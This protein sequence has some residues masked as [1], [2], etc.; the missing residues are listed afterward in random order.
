MTRGTSLLRIYA[1]LAALVAGIWLAESVP[2]AV[3][4]GAGCCA[5]VAAGWRRRAVVS[6]IG[7]M[8]T[9]ASCGVLVTTLRA[10]PSPLQPLADRIPHCELTGRLIEH[11]GGLG[12]LVSAD[13]V[14]CDGFAPGRDAGVVVVDPSE[15]DSGAIVNAAGWLIPLRIDDTF[16][17]ARRR[18]GAHTAF[19]VEEIEQRVAPRGLHALAAD[20]RAGL[21]RGTAGM[22][23]ERA[24]LLS[25]LTTGDTTG[26]G[27]A[28]EEQLRRAGLS[29]LVAVS[30]SNV[31]I[32]VGA[33]A[34]MVS[35]L[36][37]WIRLVACGLALGLFVLVVGPEPSVLRAAVM[38]AVGLLALALGRRTE[39]LHAF[40]LALVV[41]L[42][43]RPGLVWSVGL[44][45]SAA[46]TAGIIL[47]SG[48]VTRAMSGLPRFVS[49]PLAVTLAAQFAVAPV[50]VGT[51]GELS[52]VAPL[53]NL[54]AVPAVAPAT[55]LGLASAV[56]G[57][58]V[59]P[60]GWLCAR[61][62]EP[63]VT[64]VLAVGR[65]T[66]GWSWASIDVPE[67]WAWALWA[68]VIA[69]ALGS[70]S[71]TLTA[72]EDAVRGV[73]RLPTLTGGK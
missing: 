42:A 47:F 73:S 14:N 18:L 31:A 57:T 9:A 12:S 53:A 41:L 38:G 52:L 15:I 51:F 68:L 37:L 7:L 59:P 66:G 3:A 24:G 26:M 60:L 2:Q 44:H 36:A 16:D 33:A 23:P 40:G 61:I 22:D 50:L 58:L 56:A 1:A 70:Q 32:V 11:A 62:A 54:L 43:L 19:H 20:V 13:L 49:L 5:V 30:G 55:V 69:A 27:G 46:A 28:T 67:A 45:L 6:L 48:H 35:R 63:F 65:T 71:R 64:W 72:R 39:P 34:L 4:V 29:H 21:D 25:G 8:A 10:S 17:E